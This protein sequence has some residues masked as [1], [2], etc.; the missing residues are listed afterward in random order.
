VEVASGSLAANYLVVNT[1]A[2]SARI[3]VE[4]PVA[5]EVADVSCAIWVSFAINHRAFAAVAPVH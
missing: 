3:P 4:V 5:D 1:I 2:F